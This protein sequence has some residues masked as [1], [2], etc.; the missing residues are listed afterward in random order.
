LQWNVGEAGQIRASFARTARRPSLDQLVPFEDE[1][2]PGDDDITVGN[3]NL[4]IETAYG[5]DI[6]YEHRIGDRGVIGFNYFHRDVSNLISLVRTPLACACA[7]GLYTY[8]NIGDGEVWGW[9]VDVSTPLGFIGLRDTG[10]FANYTDLNSERT[11]PFTGIETTFNAQ[12]EY[13]Y[14]W[15]ITHNMEA[16]RT[17][18]G[19]SYRK[20]GMSRSLFL[21]EIEDQW[22]DANL[23]VF[24]EHRITNSMVIR[25]VANNLLDADSTQAERNFDGDSA[26]ELRDAMLAN[27]VDEFEIE[28]EN[29]S[30]TLL[31]TL[32]AVF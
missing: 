3:P 23:E 18:F 2:S 27:D 1:E 28:R 31:L 14:N 4:G 20:Q 16:L 12:P 9:E 15:G 32:R 13:V 22:Y 11:D 17:S 26:E 24:V 10:F 5:Y 7:G 29:S 30:P 21:G 25:L 19:F 8:D 6:G